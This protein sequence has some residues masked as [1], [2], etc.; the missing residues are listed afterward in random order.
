M[1]VLSTTHAKWGYIVAEAIIAGSSL[2]IFL[3]SLFGGAIMFGINYQI[4]K[5]NQD[6]V[7]LKCL[8]VF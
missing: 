4:S 7:S 8:G 3:T 5:K 2:P 1:S 6:R